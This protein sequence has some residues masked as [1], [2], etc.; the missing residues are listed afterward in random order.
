MIRTT[1][2]EHFSKRLRA[3]MAERGYPIDSPTFLMHEFNRHSKDL[4]VSVHAARKWLLGEAIP[5]QERILVL[6]RW[7]G[8]GPEWLRFDEDEPNT[9]S[10]LFLPSLRGGSLAAAFDALTEERQVV[11]EDLVRMLGTTP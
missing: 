3:T 6:C 8:V 10:E 5:T 7:L 4:H 2:Q 1:Q 9:V 11:V